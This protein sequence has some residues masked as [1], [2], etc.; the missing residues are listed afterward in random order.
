[1][2]LGVMV[3]PKMPAAGAPKDSDYKVYICQ[4]S[5]AVLMATLVRHHVTP[6]YPGDYFFSHFFHG[7]QHLQ[8][9]QGHLW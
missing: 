2:V 8:L 3:V 4:D 6:F 9:H 7:E 5:F 1:M